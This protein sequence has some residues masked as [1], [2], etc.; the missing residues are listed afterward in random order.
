MELSELFCMFEESV[1][2]DG[3]TAQDLSVGPE[4]P[5]AEHKL[6]VRGD[7]DGLE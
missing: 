4:S 6:V 3:V 5:L 7:T 1:G 2:G